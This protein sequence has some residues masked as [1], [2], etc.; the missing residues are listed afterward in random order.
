MP[1]DLGTPTTLYFVALAGQAP[2][3]L[4]AYHGMNI[5]LT[6]AQMT[7]IPAG[8]DVVRAW[9]IDFPGYRRPREGGGLEWVIAPLAGPNEDVIN[10]LPGPGG[11]KDAARR[12]V[13]A[14]A[15]ERFRK[16]GVPIQAIRNR[17]PALWAAAAAEVRAQ[18]AAKA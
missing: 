8:P 9:G 16:D 15:D 4:L 11:W 18:D 2:D 12:Q 3:S 14:A 17:F 10:A 5:G 7:S 6:E 13:W 1:V